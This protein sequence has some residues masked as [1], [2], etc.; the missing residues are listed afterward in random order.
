VRFIKWSTPIAWQIVDGFRPRNK[1]LKSQRIGATLQTTVQGERLSLQYL[2]GP[3]QGRFAVFVNDSL[4]GLVNSYSPTTP[5]EL[6]RIDWV[7][8]P[9]ETTNILLK[10]IAS[11]S[12]LASTSIRSLK[13]LSQSSPSSAREMAAR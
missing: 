8:D 11:K 2:K 4:L 3:R 1:I 7:I 12:R 6:T 5:G 9:A 10:T 13:V